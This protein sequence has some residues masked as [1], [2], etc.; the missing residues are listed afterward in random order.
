MT[1]VGNLSAEKPAAVMALMI[2]CSRFTLMACREVH[3]EHISEAIVRQ[4]SC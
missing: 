3:C 2:A 1:S 4:F